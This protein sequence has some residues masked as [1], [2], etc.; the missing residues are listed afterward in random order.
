MNSK[1]I[2][3]YFFTIVLLLITVGFSIATCK[4]HVAAIGPQETEVGFYELNQMVHNMT[5]PSAEL[6]KESGFHYICY[7]A[8][9]I[10]GFVACF[11]AFLFAIMGLQQWIGRRKIFQVDVEILSY[12]L[13]LLTMFLLYVF[14]LKF[15]INLRPVIMEGEIAPESSFPSSHTMLS[16]V[17]FLG[18]SR[19]ISKYVPN[20]G[21]A[22][23]ANFL[24][25][26]LTAAAVIGRV[27][28]GV[29]WATDIIAGLL[30]SA[31]LL[32]LED[33]II[34]TFDKDK[35]YQGAHFKK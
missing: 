20:R 21:W 3:K 7:E 25:L 17:V 10:I 30:I 4:Y 11:V 18:A 6:F 26:A 8:T 24:C 16:I 22:I 31:T 32:V 23:T 35:Y 14:F 33:A 29:H 28:S 2:L 34:C 15:P 13:I 1:V 27:L 12:G 5:G 19:I 9:Q